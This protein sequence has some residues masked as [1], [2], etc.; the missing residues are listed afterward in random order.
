MRK[1]N[2]RVGKD[3]IRARDY[4]SACASAG[5]SALTSRFC[6]YGDYERHD[7]VGV[8]VGGG[9]RSNGGKGEGYLTGYVSFIPETQRKD[10]KEWWE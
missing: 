3:I 7:Y 6:D 1:L 9:R 4:E 2:I 8:A 10:R 5:V